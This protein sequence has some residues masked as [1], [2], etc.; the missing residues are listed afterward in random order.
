MFIAVAE[1]GDVGDFP[2]W[3]G[4]SLLARVEKA[5]KKTSKK[6]LFSRKKFGRRVAG[7][8]RAPVVPQITKGSVPVGTLFGR[9]VESGKLRPRTCF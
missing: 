5:P 4:C 1:A 6:L 2:F 3:D 9:Q 7:Y 8:V